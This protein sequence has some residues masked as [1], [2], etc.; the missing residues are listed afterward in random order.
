MSLF[1][2]TTKVST[3]VARINL[4]YDSNFKLPLYICLLDK[5]YVFNDE[6]NITLQQTKPS[7]IL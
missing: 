6:D 3:S 2:G 5:S 7:N 1:N 4:V